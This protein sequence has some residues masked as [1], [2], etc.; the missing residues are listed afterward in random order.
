MRLSAEATEIDKGNEDNNKN[1]ENTATADHE[2]REANNENKEETV[3]PEAVD[4]SQSKKETTSSRYV[5]NII[6]QPIC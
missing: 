1:E 6:R 4:L 3:E 2:N 5:I